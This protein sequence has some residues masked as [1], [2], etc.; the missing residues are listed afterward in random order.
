VASLRYGACDQGAEAMACA[1]PV[2]VTTGGAKASIQPTV[3]RRGLTRR[4]VC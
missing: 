3:T 2:V 4:G 1:T